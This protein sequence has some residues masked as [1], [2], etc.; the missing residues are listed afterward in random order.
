[1]L[2][3][4]L[5]P[6]ERALFHPEHLPSGVVFG[7]ALAPSVVAGLWF[8]RTQAAAMLAV[9]IG[10][11]IALQL[12]ARLLRL[13]TGAG[14]ILPAV[15]GVGLIGPGAALQWSITVAV[16]AGLFEL[17]RA[18]LVPDARVHTGLL[19]YA[20]IYLTEGGSLDHYYN[21]SSGRLASE[22]ISL[23]ISFFGAGSSPIDPI[24]LYVGNVAGPVFATSLLAMAIGGAWLW[25][26]RRLSVPV[27]VGFLIGALVPIK[28]FGWNPA[29][30]LISGPMWFVAALILADRQLL[31]KGRVSP[32]L[33]GVAAG[34]SIMAFRQRGIG[35]EGAFLTVAA[36]QVTVALVEGMG[37]VI[38]NRVAIWQALRSAQSRG[39]QL[40]LATARRDTA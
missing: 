22:P 40:S 16:A 38:A 31:P 24:R 30:Q 17:I 14:M 25:Y 13:P 9:A 10:V 18:S 4:L 33:L 27:L 19:G 23:W 29:F 39:G 36:L 20:A 37:W 28:V 7:I 6:L 32:A 1:M 34:V 21:P 5:G 15:V 2:G 11:G 12:L 26:A 35:I 8:Y 3:R